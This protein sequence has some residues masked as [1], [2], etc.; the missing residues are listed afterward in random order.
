LRRTLT[1]D[2]LICNI[3]KAGIH[4]F[5]FYR[6]PAFIIYIFTQRSTTIMKILCADN[7]SR[8]GNRGSFFLRVALFL[9]LLFSSLYARDLL[10]DKQHSAVSRIIAGLFTHHHYNHKAIDD[11]ASAALLNF[12]LDD[13]DPYR[14]IFLESDV[15]FFAKYRHQLD[16]YLTRG[17][18]APAF[19]IYNLFDKRFEERFAHIQKTIAQGFDFTT[20]EFYEIE[21]ENMPWA[22]TPAELNERWRKRLKNEA[23][24]LKLNGKSDEESVPN[25]T[26]RYANFQKRI[27]Q[28]TAED[29]FQA[30][31]NAL[32]QVF[33]P[34]TNYLSPI[35]SQ[36]FGIDMSLSLE[37]IG[38]QLT[39][40]ADYYTAVARIIPGGPADMSKQLWANDK[41]VAVGQG[42]N[43]EMVDVVGMRLDD[44]VQLIRGQKGTIVRLDVLPKSSPAGTVPKRISLVRDKIILKEGEA[45]SDTLTLMHEGR[46]FTLGVVVI[47]TFYSDLAAQNRGEQEYKSTT[48]DVR[49]L[50]RELKG[51]KVDGLVIDLR[52]DSGGSL[53]EAIELTGLFIDKGPVVQVRNSDGSVKVMPD[54]D[55]AIEYDGPLA[56]LVNRRSASASEI[57][58][59]AIQDYGRGAVIGSQTFGKGTVQ[60]LI[61]LD[62]L[63]PGS[64][65]RLGQ[66]KLTVA[67]FY[68]IAGGTTQHRGVIPD[69][70]FPSIWDEQEIGES[71]EINALPWDEIQAAN[72]SSKGRLAQYLPLLR[73]KS[74]KR[75]ALN[76]E[77]RFLTEDIG[78]FKKE[79]ARTQI[80]LNEATRRQER[81]QLE[82][83][84]FVRENERR[85]ARG[86]KPLK[87]GEK[88]PE[89]QNQPDFVLDESTRILSDL[90]N[91]SSAGQKMLAQ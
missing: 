74:K 5:A 62:R 36:N 65:A 38:A 66:L 64:D 80:S 39:T 3:C 24:N 21:I 19:E 61:D 44:V 58:A 28:N 45:R 48:R 26:K 31:M 16:D 88:T 81:E 25:L 17:D 60:N 85:V 79:S 37:G 6:I 87:K 23:L 63:M 29:V 68:R 43:G 10:P 20:N 22:K 46:K 72:Y 14:S 11:S 73:D 30:Y 9:V 57:F 86:L 13:L 12:Y 71:A 7:S 40:E 33:D 27:A 56:V 49:R 35:A 32:S 4:K 15:K 76:L 50:I 41:I 18:L 8:T 59:A 91:L 42:E 77:F 89:N 52:G 51:A 82:E 53:Q 1:R 2:P 84:R 34:H 67:K 70:A 69:L 78:R 83:Q 55:P 75:T 54:P 90:I 47:P